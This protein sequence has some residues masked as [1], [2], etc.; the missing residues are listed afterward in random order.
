MSQLPVTVV[1]S[2]RRRKTLSAQ[3]VDG[4]V[5]VL[6]PAGMPPE[7]EEAMVASLVDRVTRKMTAGHIDLES[8][9]RHLSR[10]YGLPRP[11]AIEW[12]DRQLARWGSCTPAHGKIRISNRLAEMP[13]WVLDYVLVHELAHLEEA[14]HG[15]RFRQLVGRYEL[16]ERATGY[17]MAIT[18]SASSPAEMNHS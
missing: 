17:L 18:G 16:S 9:V 10:S 4:T 6:V 3:I 13:D 11:D 14:N 5:R 1:R 15:P 2:G 8:R 12:S 7:E